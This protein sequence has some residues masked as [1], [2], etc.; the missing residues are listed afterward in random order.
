M[1]ALHLL[2]SALV[3]AL[4]HA[5]RVDGRTSSG[6]V[7]ILADF[8]ECLDIICPVGRAAAEEKDAKCKADYEKCQQEVKE[9]ALKVGFNPGF[10]LEDIASERCLKLKDQP[11]P[12]CGWKFSFLSSQLEEFI[13]ERIKTASSV[14][15]ISA[16]ARQTGVVENCLKEYE[17]SHENSLEAFAALAQQKR[18][19]YDSDKWLLEK[20]TTEQAQ[21]ALANAANIIC[22]PGNS[23]RSSHKRWMKRSAAQH[24]YRS[25]KQ[26]GTTIYHFDAESPTDFLRKFQP[27]SPREEY[28]PEL[29]E[30]VTVYQIPFN[31]DR[32]ARGDSLE[33]QTSVKYGR[34]FKFPCAYELKKDEATKRVCLSDWKNVN[35]YLQS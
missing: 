30:G 17:G 11:P 23:A 32:L 14:E 13:L 34:Q 29:Q 9:A 27:E 7:V 19:L 20:T 6:H 2:V 8:F 5:E 28:K 24:V 18:W 33:W 35:D 16:S 22:D 21:I 10:K 3:L 1:V 12:D 25:N 4:V 31:W 26:A 15:L